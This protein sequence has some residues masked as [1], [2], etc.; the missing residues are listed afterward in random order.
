MQALSGA[1]A[2][3]YDELN[4]DR[5]EDHS[6]QEEGSNRAFDEEGDENVDR[7][8]TDQEVEDAPE[9]TEYEALRLR[10]IA[11]NKDIF[12]ELCLTKP[13]APPTVSNEFFE[14]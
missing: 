2:L 7:T 10:N 11:R 4:D 6:D 8:E 14:H 5:N 9:I 13:E 12:V 1:S 3:T